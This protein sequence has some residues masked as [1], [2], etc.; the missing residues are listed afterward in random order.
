MPD[1]SKTK[2][3]K[4]WSHSGDKI[5]IGSTCKNYLSERM[6]SHRGQYAQWKKNNTRDRISSFDLFEEY[7]LQIV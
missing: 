7:E 2:I 4:I 5:Y 3:Y 6:T 1:Y